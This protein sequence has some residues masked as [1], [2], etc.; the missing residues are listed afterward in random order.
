MRRYPV[1]PIYPKSMAGMSMSQWWDRRELLYMLWSKAWIHR[2]PKDVQQKHG[3]DTIVAQMCKKH[4][5]KTLGDLQ[6]MA[7]ERAGK[8]GSGDNVNIHIASET[9]S[10][11]SAVAQ[12]KV[13][14]GALGVPVMRK[15]CTILGLKA[16]CP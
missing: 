9:P 13:E 3:K 2:H 1:L 7:L 14:L 10:D 8:E 4:A 16:Q 12:L 6:T 15:L 11:A 5:K